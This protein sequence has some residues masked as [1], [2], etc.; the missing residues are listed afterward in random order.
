MARIN[1]KKNQMPIIRLFADRIFRQVYNSTHN[2]LQ[3]YVEV[4]DVTPL[5]IQ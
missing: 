2:S 3:A 1:P 5:Q 4:Y